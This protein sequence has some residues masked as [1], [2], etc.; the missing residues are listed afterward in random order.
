M[1]VDPLLINVAIEN[2]SSVISSTGRIG[3]FLAFTRNLNGP[4]VAV[5]LRGLGTMNDQSVNGRPS[6]IEAYTVISCNFCGLVAFFPIVWDRVVRDR[7]NR[8]I[9]LYERVS[10]LANGLCHFKAEFGTPLG[11]S[12]R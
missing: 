9:R 12:R 8:C 10:K 4:V 1:D 11:V 5:G 7:L 2:A 6:I 3:P